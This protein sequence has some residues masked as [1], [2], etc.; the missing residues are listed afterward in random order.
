MDP[1]TMLLIGGTALD[2][3]GGYGAN[4][5]QSIME[6]ANAQ[7]YR[8]QA[9]FNM[10]AMQRDVQAAEREA[11]YKLG[12]AVTTYGASGVDVSSSSAIVNMA[13]IIADG[14]QEVE[15]AR[16]K[17]ELDIQLAQMRGNM[18]QSKADTLGSTGYNL[19]Q[20]GT[21]G[22]EGAARY[23][24][25]KPSGTGGSVNRLTGS[26]SLSIGSDNSYLTGSSEGSGT[27]Y[28]GNYNY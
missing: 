27:G 3:V 23:F 10:L 15:Y 17:G 14:I 2:I 12:Q 4:I 7:F 8:D 9:K 25:N 6:K 28:L 13:T 21:K 22:A 24:A 18:A 20:A 19:L 1:A 5:Q 16:R 11:G 26:K